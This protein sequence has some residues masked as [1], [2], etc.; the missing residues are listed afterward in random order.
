[1][2]DPCDAV[3]GVITI[4]VGVIV[5]R[6]RRG[7][8]ADSNNRIQRDS[9]STS[10]CFC[11]KLRRF[12]GQVSRRALAAGP[13]QMRSNEVVKPLPP[14]GS[15]LDLGRHS[16]LRYPDPGGEGLSRVHVEFG[17]GLESWSR[18]PSRSLC[19]RP[20]STPVFSV[21]SHVFPFL[22]APC[23]LHSDG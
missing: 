8:G 23:D 14:D 9:N 22:H 18:T 20:P 1:M 11:R 16:S 3:N 12:A 19:P 4:V 21:V 13:A 10:F 15:Q 5:G 2:A 6:L 17:V 7:G